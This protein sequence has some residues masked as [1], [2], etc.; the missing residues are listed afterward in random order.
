MKVRAIIAYDGTNYVGWQVQPNGLSVQEEVNRCLS[1]LLKEDIHCI[2]A[3]RTDAGVHS[4][5]NVICF[6]TNTRM[7]AEKIAIALNSYLPE[8]IVCQGSMEASEDFNPRHSKSIKTYEYKILNRKY[9]MPT[10]RRDTLFCRYPLDVEKMNTAAQYLAGEHDFTSFSNVHA[11]SNT[12]VRTI[13]Q[14]GVTK[15]AADIIHIRVQGSGFL[16]NM[17]RIIAGTL[18]EV[19]SGRMAVDAIPGILEAKD[20]SAAGPTA[21]AHGLTQIGIQYFN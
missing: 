9:P 20:R 17:V 4:L 16:Y 13:Y 10:V 18:I 19:G 15:D 2:G 5:G 21:P 12:R 11:Q 8:D 6:E 14:I 7:P 3:S 1:E